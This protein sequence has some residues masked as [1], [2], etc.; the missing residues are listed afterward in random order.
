MRETEKQRSE[1]KRNLQYHIREEQQ[2]VYAHNNRN[3]TTVKMGKEKKKKK[4]HSKEKPEELEE[5]CFIP[6][7]ARKQRRYFLRMKMK[8]NRLI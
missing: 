8:M 5:I 2:V 3:R 1:V 6:L 4:M 7:I